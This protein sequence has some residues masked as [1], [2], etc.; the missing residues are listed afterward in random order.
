MD[1][2]VGPEGLTTPNRPETGKLVM[3]IFGI[4]KTNSRYGLGGDVEVER[5]CGVPNANRSK[6]A[7]LPFSNPR[8][9]LGVA[10]RFSHCFY[11]TGQGK[12]FIKLLQ[13]VPETGH[14]LYIT[15]PRS[16]TQAVGL[17]S[18]FPTSPSL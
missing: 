9:V 18:P 13:R 6:R 5:K 8:Q 16:P 1:M 15:D 10:S 7:K 4:V 11:F 17:P 3:E 14:I 2:L 12:I